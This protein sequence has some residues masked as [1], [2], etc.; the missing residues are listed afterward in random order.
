[1]G[2]LNQVQAIAMF[3]AIAGLLLTG[4]LVSLASGLPVLAGRRGLRLFLGNFY[5]VLI[6][7]LA[8]VV[9]FLAL[10]QLIGFPLDFL[11]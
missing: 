8:Y 10:Q 3:G 6:Q 1:M 4:L 2:W 9:G 5:R 11:W 7:L